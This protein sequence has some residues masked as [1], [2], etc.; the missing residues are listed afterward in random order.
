ML[1][2]NRVT[3]YK[4]KI[5]NLANKIKKADAIVVGIGAGMT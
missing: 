3:T 2:I 4:D 1:C 5:N